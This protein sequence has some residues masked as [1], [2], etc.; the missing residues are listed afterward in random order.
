LESDVSF[1]L[2]VYAPEWP[3]DLGRV[4]QEALSRHGLV[5][6]VLPGFSVPKW[7]GGFLPF[8]LV[9]RPGSFPAAERYGRDALLAGF[10]VGFQPEEAADLEDFAAEASPEAA[11]VYRNARCSAYLSTSMGRTVADLRVQCFAA[12][13]LALACGGLVSDG[14]Q[15]MDFMGD[16]A[17]QNAVREADDFDERPISER[18]WDLVPFPGWG[19]LGG[20]S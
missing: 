3:P 20:A 4:W 6:E 14:Q 12:A 2:S 5:V 9:V 16:G 8:R 19:A 17:I 18:D 11:A 10:E 13:T 15:G 1:G 7:K